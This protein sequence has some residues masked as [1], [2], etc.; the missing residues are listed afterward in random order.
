VA[1]TMIEAD[2]VTPFLVEDGNRYVAAMPIERSH[3]GQWRSVVM[4]IGDDGTDGGGRR[5]LHGRSILG[6]QSLSTELTRKIR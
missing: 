5:P 2:S 4:V 1:D 6:P 3:R